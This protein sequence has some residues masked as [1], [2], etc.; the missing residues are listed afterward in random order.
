M[1]MKKKTS[2]KQNTFIIIRLQWLVFIKMAMLNV[3]LR[4]ILKI[5][6]NTLMYF[7]QFHI[8]QK[9]YTISYAYKNIFSL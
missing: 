8:L 2:K 9:N 5:L 4:S 3:E 1:L 7:H 6:I